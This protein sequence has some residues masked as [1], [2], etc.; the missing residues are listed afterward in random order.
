MDKTQIWEAVIKRLGEKLSRMEFGTWFRRVQVREISGGAMLIS[1]PTE[2]NKNWLENKYANIILTNVQKVC[3]EIQHVY[4]E[5]DLTLA[6]KK[7]VVSEQIF[8]PTKAPRKMPN[9]PEVRLEEGIESRV[10]QPKFTLQNFVVGD[11]NRFAH[12]ATQTVAD[13]SISSP[14]K[15]NPLFIYGGVGLG[16]THLLQGLAN[17]IIRKHPEAKVVYTTSER[18]INEIVAAAKNRR[19]DD[20]RKKYRRIDTLV[21]DDIQ[22]FED[23]EKTQEELFNT[24]NDLYEFNKQIVFSAD[25]AP[26]QLNGI[27]QRLGSRMEWGLIVDIQMPGYETRLAIVAEKARSM[28][29]VLPN[30]VLEFIAINTRRHLRE[31]E[32]VLHKIDA[33]IEISGI[34]PTVP[35]V[36]KIFRK[37]NPEEPVITDINAAK[38]GLVRSVDDVITAVS[39][40]FQIPATD[41]MGLS[42]KKEII[43]PR[44]IIW[45]FCKETLHM[46]YDAI[47]RYFKGKNHTTIMHGVKKVEEMSR[48]DTA[49]AR[50]LHAIRKELG[51]Q[52]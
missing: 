9:R 34:S 39:E 35:S 14:K 16:K 45:L 37:T 19:L 33:E 21:I 20:F 18:F 48:N 47:G 12:A 49:M 27:S 52:N 7:N 50:H 4:F 41:L 44:Q 31:M 28:G 10:V 32:T 29:L 42:R 36:A 11:E 5:V 38:K 8:E 51:V 17:E 43:V 26:S 23:K 3:P 30:D 40:Y 6:D 24:F 22:F 13:T 46:S 15:Y 25:R 2:M 1:C